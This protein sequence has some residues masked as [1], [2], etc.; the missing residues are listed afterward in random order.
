MGRRGLQIFL[1]VLGV[2]A[3]TV[4][5]WTVLRGAAAIT[6]SGPVSPTIDSE[7]RFANAWY[8]G[9][10]AL[11]LYVARRP[12]AHTALIRGMCSVLLVA[13]AGRGVSWATV[14]RPEGLY[15]ALLAVEVLIAA[16]VWPWQTAVARRCAGET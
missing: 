12:E 6:G 16:V 3:V 1:V 11:L 9:A 8:A 5:A 10:G 4:G 14:G 7:L 13:A 15:L 2:V